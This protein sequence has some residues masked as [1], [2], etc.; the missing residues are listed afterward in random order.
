METDG[1]L[2]Q[3][4]PH[5]NIASV[6]HTAP[7]PS[8]QSPSKEGGVPTPPMTSINLEVPDTLREALHRA[9]IV[10]E[11]RALMGTEP[12]VHYPADRF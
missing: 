8:E 4:G 9:S 12:S 11:H 6:S 10:D 2:D 1:G 3:A 5:P 7:D